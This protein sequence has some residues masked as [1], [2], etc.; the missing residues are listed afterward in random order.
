M[1]MKFINSSYHWFLY[2]DKNVDCDPI[3]CKVHMFV[4]FQFP[5]HPSHYANDLI[6]VDQKLVISLSL[7]VQLSVYYIEATS[8]HQIWDK[9]RKPILIS[10]HVLCNNLVQIIENQFLDNDKRQKCANMGILI[11]VF[12]YMCKTPF[13]G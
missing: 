9:T 1:F 11:K 2:Q 13:E 7:K 8:T 10:K 4:E 12:C 5:L 6:S 3:A